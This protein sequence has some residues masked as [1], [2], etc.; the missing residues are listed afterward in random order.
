MLHWSPKSAWGGIKQRNI[1]EPLSARLCFAAAIGDCADFFGDVY[2]GNMPCCEIL[3][4]LCWVKWKHIT[5]MMNNAGN[6]VY[7]RCFCI[8]FVKYCQ[9]YLLICPVRFW[10]DNE[11]EK[12]ENIANI[13]FIILDN[14]PF[15]LL[16]EILLWTKN[17]SFVG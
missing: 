17:R 11:S 10:S 14:M 8:C 15:R 13:L 16:S 1:L 5:A 12:Y 3:C 9:I 4:P 7:V 2:K 6:L